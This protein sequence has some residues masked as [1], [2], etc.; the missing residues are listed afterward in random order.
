MV[1]FSQMETSKEFE[2][3]DRMRLTVG[4]RARACLDGVLTLNTTQWSKWFFCLS[5]FNLERV[6]QTGHVR[7][8]RGR[9]LE[10]HTLITARIQNNI[11]QTFI[12]LFVRYCLC[13][14][15]THGWGKDNRQTNKYITTQHDMHSRDKSMDTG[16]MEGTQRKKY[17]RRSPGR[18]D[19]LS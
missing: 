8:K 2:E 7:P 6:Q 3:A 1:L 17:V 13:C 5:T 9:W 15:G 10:R 16:C 14:Q 18:D 19:N 12:E 11:N 4:E